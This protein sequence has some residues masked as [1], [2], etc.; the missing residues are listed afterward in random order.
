MPA[1]TLWATLKGYQLGK[2]ALA[3]GKTAVKQGFSLTAG[4]QGVS[5]TQRGSTVANAI[6]ASTGVNPQIITV[7]GIGLLAYLIFKK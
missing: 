6:G 3:F 5:Y 7:G 4:K 1:G 2:K